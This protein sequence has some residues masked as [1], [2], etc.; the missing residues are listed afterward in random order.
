MEEDH[1]LISYIK[2]YAVSFFSI[3]QVLSRCANG[4]TRTVMMDPN[5]AATAVNKPMW[6][7]A[8]GAYVV[9]Y[10]NLAT[11]TS[12]ATNTSNVADNSGAVRH[13]GGSALKEVTVA[14]PSTFAARRKDFTIECV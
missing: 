2:L 7:L 10:T 9:R 1:P 12:T 13:F 6:G 5:A 14:N 3:P 8:R 4:R 11:R